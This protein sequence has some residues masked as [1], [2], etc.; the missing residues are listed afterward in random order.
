M[1]LGNYCDDHKDF[2]NRIIKLE[3]VT[4]DLCKNFNKLENSLLALITKIE[5]REKIITEMQE[6]QIKGQSQAI[7][8]AAVIVGIITI[9]A[10]ALIAII[11]G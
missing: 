7:A 10:Q 3:V 1:A 8:K 6:K 4:D 5:E 9:I 11:G 2:R